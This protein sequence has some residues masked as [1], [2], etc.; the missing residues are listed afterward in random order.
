MNAGMTRIRNDPD[1]NASLVSSNPRRH[2]DDH[3]CANPWN[4]INNNKKHCFCWWRQESGCYLQLEIM[5]ITLSYFADN[6][7]GIIEINIFN[8]K[9]KTCCGEYRKILG[10]KSPDLTVVRPGCPITAKSGPIMG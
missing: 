3:F 4:L 7:H 9:L 6:E 1:R 2:V 8:M 10:E 5:I